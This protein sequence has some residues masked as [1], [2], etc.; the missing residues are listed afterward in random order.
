MLKREFV[1]KHPIFINPFCGYAIIWLLTVA[2]Y[3]IS[4]SKLN[5]PMNF[6]VLFF[7][8]IS[9]AISLLVSLFFNQKY[10][11]KSFI[12]KYNFKYRKITAVILI[13]L[14]LLEFYYSGQIP[15]LSSL[16]A[17][18]SYKEFG[19]PTLHVVIS[20]FSIF[21]AI[22]N[23]FQ[24]IVFKQVGSLLSL[25]LPFMFFVLIFSRGM[26]ILVVF[27]LIC[28]FMCQAKIN[29]KTVV[30]LILLLLF[31]AWSF[32][33]LGNIRMGYAWNDTGYFLSVAEIDYDR[34]SLLAPFFWVE[35]YLVCSFRNLLYNSTYTPSGDVTGVLYCII[36]DFLSKRIFSGLNVDIHLVRPELTTGTA[37]SFSY[38]SM[39]MVGMMTV[40]LTYMVVGILLMNIKMKGEYKIVIFSLLM[41]CFCLSIF[42]NMLFYSGQSFVIIFALIFAFWNRLK[43]SYLNYKVL[44]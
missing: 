35:E 14:Y 21:Y 27:S 24:F 43:G 38:L 16:Q 15:L 40:F 34:Y 17:N 5:V 6:E 13:I 8:F 22:Y 2:M 1:I 26:I 32:G 7:V 20:T 42:D 10:K 4:P 44:I 9:V 11:N 30:L 41:Y 36:P 37:F 19:I 28:I 12:V 33:V 29:F 31:G 3:S 25:A 39:G 23:G 18:V